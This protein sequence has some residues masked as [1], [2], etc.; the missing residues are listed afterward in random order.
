MVYRGP[1][2]EGI[3]SDEFVALGIR[4]LSIIDLTGGKQPLHNEDNTLVCVCNGEVYNYVELRQKLQSHGH[5]FKTDSDAEVVLHLYEE[6]VEGCLKYLRGMFA[7]V[8]WDRKKRTIFAA[9]DRVGIKP[10]Y[11]SKVNGALWLSSELKT[12]V[13]AANIS[14]TLSPISIWQYLHYGY[15]V[16]QGNTMIEEV[17]RVLPGEYLLANS[18]EIIRKRYWEPNFSGL[19]GIERTDTEIL[20]VFEE[21]V[22]L[23]LRSD[24]PIGVML[25]S[26][27]DSSTI[28]ALA[29]RVGGDYTAV[30]AGYVGRHCCDERKDAHLIAQSLDIPYVDILLDAGQFKENFEALVKVCDEPIADMAAIPQ[31]AIYKEVHNQ[32]Y[33]VLLSGIGGDEVFFGYRQ[34]N[35]VGQR[36]NSLFTEVGGGINSNVLKYLP[37]FLKDNWVLHQLAS[38][39]LQTVADSAHKPVLDLLRKSS[40]GPEAVYAMLFSTYLVHNGCILADKLG[41]GSSVEVRVPLLD[42]HL[43]ETIFNLPLSRRF[44]P[45]KSKVLLR[46]VMSKDL[47]K[48]I[49][50]NPKRGFAVPRQFI[51]EIISEHQEEIREGVLAKQWLKADFLEDIL[52]SYFSLKW[53]A[54]GKIGRSITTRAASF[55]LKKHCQALAYKIN[56]DL[57]ADI[58]YRILVFERWYKLIKS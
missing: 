4:R 1:D 27:I 23:H 29:R 44:L 54:G 5:I 10:L 15:P 41:M 56:H 8:L 49:L 57:F 40:T 37:Y 34:W 12:I 47:P 35:G 38:S 25:S 2:D 43:V 22:R 14:P 26:G 24:V 58:L 30:C 11:I 48:R 28:S 7:F 42:H 55:F 52:E 50:N 39:E 33:K 9:R 46:R 21:A 53:S 31:W 18:K 51:H 13:G 6:Y 32:G 3:Y 20:T 16:D 36:L 45:G 19:H 17:K